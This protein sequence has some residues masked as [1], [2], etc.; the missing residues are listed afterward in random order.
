VG[1]M[2]CYGVA[3]LVSKQRGKASNHKACVLLRKQITE[4]A[5][6]IYSGFGPTL[7]AKKLLEN[8]DLKVSKEW[9]RQLLMQETLWT[10]RR[11][12]QASVHQSCEREPVLVSWFN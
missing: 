6:E 12:K 7:M 3:A 2:R 11:S 10:A 1:I 5:S 8:H 9:L 4:L